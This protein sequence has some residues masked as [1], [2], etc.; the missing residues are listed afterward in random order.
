[1]SREDLAFWI[2]VVSAGCWILCF[3]WM[4]RIS[5][6]QDALLAELR[7]QASRIER[8]SKMEHDLIRDVHPQVGEIKKAV[9]EVASSLTAGDSSLTTNTARSKP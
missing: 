4:H 5:A 9:K 8:L 7:A 3:W 6:R 1:M 2:A